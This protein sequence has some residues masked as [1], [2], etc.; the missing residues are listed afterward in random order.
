MD[1]GRWYIPC[2]VPGLILDPTSAAAQKVGKAMDAVP[3]SRWG[4]IYILLSDMDKRS[5]DDIYLSVTS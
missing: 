3:L 2:T 4:N 5:L 1:H